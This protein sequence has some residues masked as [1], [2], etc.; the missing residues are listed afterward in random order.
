[1]AQ[2]AYRKR[3]APEFRFHTGGIGKALFAGDHL[4]PLIEVYFEAYALVCQRAAEQSFIVGHAA[5]K[6][7]RKCDTALAA[8]GDGFAMGTA[9][10]VH[11]HR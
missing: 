5:G 1:M 2:A 8:Q 6:N 7:A 10:A 4:E 9:F 11:I 3:T